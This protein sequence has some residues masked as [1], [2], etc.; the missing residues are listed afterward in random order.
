MQVCQHLLT[1]AGHDLDEGA[2]EKSDLEAQWCQFIGAAEGGGAA[3]QQ[4]VDERDAVRETGGQGLRLFR[5]GEAFGQQ[6]VAA[7]LDIGFATLQR[8][9]ERD[10]GLGVGTGRDQD[11]LAGASV[12]GGLQ[13]TQHLG[14]GDERSGIDARQWLERDLIFDLYGAGAG[15][16]EAA[17]GSLQVQRAAMAAVGVDENGDA[18]PVGDA[19]A[20]VRKFCGGVEAEIRAAKAGI[21]EAGA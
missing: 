21:G 13:A 12:L 20:G 4:V 10:Q 16:G 15:A 8:L 19:G 7:G 17:H 11:V 5:G 2:G 18:D 9:G 6:Q 3:F 1:C 14:E